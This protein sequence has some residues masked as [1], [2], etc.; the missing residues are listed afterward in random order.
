MNPRLLLLMIVCVWC[1][2]PA[3]AQ[4]TVT[5]GV[6]EPLL[7]HDDKP[8]RLYVYLIN[9]LGDAKVE[10]THTEPYDWYRYEQRAYEPDAILVKSVP[11]G[12]ASSITPED[13]YGYYI[14]EQASELRP[15]NTIWVIDYSQYHPHLDKLSVDQELSHCNEVY[16]HLEGKIPSMSYYTPAGI[17]SRLVHETT[18]A[19]ST[20][21]WDEPSLDY[22]EIDTVTTNKAVIVGQDYLLQDVY[23][24]TPF[25]FKGDQFAEHFGVSQEFVTDTYEAQGV[26]AHAIADQEL[27]DDQEEQPNPLGGSAPVTIHFQGYA[28][29]PLASRFIWILYEENKGI[30]EPIVR[31]TDRDLSYTFEEYGTYYAQ[32]EVSSAAGGCM[33]IAP[34]V[35]KIVIAESALE[36]PNAFSPGTT[37]GKNDIWY[38]VATSLVRYHCAVFTRWGN[39][40]FSSTNPNEGW[41]GK[42]NGNYMPAGVYFY[43]I[44]AEGS[45]GIIYKRSGDINLMRG[46]SIDDQKASE[47]D[48]P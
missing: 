17:M 38:V 28:N 10:A 15:C 7:A 24:D 25:T 1:G 4:Y 23:S 31:F 2:M 30:D 3:M 47:Q 21:R 45:D 14:K 46:K 18:L 29:E 48:A 39:R 20:L 13:G 27:T 33:M 34:E 32:F 16:L 6:G 37:P 22:L 12:G 41:D 40:V 9:G 35:F 36:I 11:Q 5:G 8:N 44:E 26:V 19:W 42:F 43:T